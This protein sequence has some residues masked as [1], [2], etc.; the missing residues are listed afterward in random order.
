MGLSIGRPDIK[1]QVWISKVVRGFKM[2][3]KDNFACFLNFLIAAQ[4]LAKSLQ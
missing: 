2:V 4:L 3:Q 1:N